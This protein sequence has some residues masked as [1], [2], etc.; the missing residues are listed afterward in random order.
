MLKKAWTKETR[1]REKR[2][3]SHSK[4][5]DCSTIDTQLAKLTGI[6]TKEAREQR[7]FWHSERVKHDEFHLAPRTVLDQAG[8]HAFVEPRYIW[9]ICVDAATQR[10]FLLPKFQFR[11]PKVFA[12]RPFYSYKLMASYAYGYGFTPYLIP[13]SQKMGA[14]LTWTV[15]W[16]TLCAMRD[17]FGYWP[18]VIHLN[19]DNTKLRRAWRGR[20]CGWRL[21]GDSRHAPG[22]A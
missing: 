16:L 5:N 4:C 12:Q 21:D 11:P 10:N 1:L 14:N 13:S 8:L 20:G 17:H 3:C 7:A 9:T 15:I 22:S 2:A 6:N 18:E 19:L